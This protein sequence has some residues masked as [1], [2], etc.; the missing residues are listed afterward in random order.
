MNLGWLNFF[1]KKAMFPP[2][3]DKSGLKRIYEAAKELFL[4]GKHVQALESFKSI[5]EV[6][7]NFRDVANIIDDYYN[8]ANDK[9]VAKYEAKFRAELSKES[10]DDGG[11]SGDDSGA[12]LASVPAPTSSYHSAQFI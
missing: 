5:Y 4:R 10:R 7:F 12:G 3:Y 11:E 6:A 9:W 1:R 8:L 2:T